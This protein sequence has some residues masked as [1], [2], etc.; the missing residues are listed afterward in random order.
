MRA[1]RESFGH[2]FADFHGTRARGPALKLLHRRRQRNLQPD[3]EGR[4][5]PDYPVMLY[6]FRSELMNNRGIADKRLIN[7]GVLHAE[8]LV[9]MSKHDYRLE[10]NVRFTP[11]QKMGDLPVE[12]VRPHVHVCRRGRANQLK[13]TT[14]GN[15]CRMNK[16]MAQAI[17]SQS[18]M[19]LRP[20]WYR[21]GL[22]P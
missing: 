14:A 16:A 10:P 9:N 15:F 8:R 12:H 11:N 21:R 3:H 19:G 22:W 1:C 5:F 6:L 17:R 4:R 13:A 20:A 7:P 2:A 18:V